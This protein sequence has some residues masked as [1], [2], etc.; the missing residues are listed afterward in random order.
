MPRATIAC[1][2]FLAQVCTREQWS[3]RQKE[4]EKLKTDRGSKGVAASQLAIVCGGMDR[5]KAQRLP[6]FLSPQAVCFFMWENIY[7][8]EWICTYSSLDEK[9]ICESHGLWLLQCLQYHTASHT[10]R[11]ASDIVDY[12]LL[13]CQTTV[14]QDGEMCFWN[15]EMQYWSS[16]GYCFSSFSFHPLHIWL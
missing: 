5:L 13:D 8:L 16:A 9:Y 1:K 3:K 10:E 6:P 15:T 14:C 12:R 2:W 4:K 11:Q 7:L